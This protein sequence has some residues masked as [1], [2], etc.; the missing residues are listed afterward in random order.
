MYKDLVSYSLPLVFVTLIGSLGV[1]FDSLTIGYFMDV[2]KILKY[3]DIEPIAKT[4][5]E[6]FEK[7]G[8]KVSV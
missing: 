4:A 3:K 8:I 6:H 5:K 1:W 2:E 7:S